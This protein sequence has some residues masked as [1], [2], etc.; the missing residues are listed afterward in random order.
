MEVKFAQVA[1]ALACDA[2]RSVTLIRI[3]LPKVYQNLRIAAL[4]RLRAKPSAGQICL[5]FQVLTNPQLDYR[6][7]AW[8]L[9]ETFP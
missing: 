7:K 6:G 3:D 4:T 9:L 2:K 8:A 1:Q 5:I